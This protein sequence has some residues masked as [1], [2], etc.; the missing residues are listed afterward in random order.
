MF[1]YVFCIITYFVNI[2]S[3]INKICES[4]VLA[5]LIDQIIMYEERSRRRKERDRAK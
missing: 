5:C 3:F 1:T 4:H 2:F